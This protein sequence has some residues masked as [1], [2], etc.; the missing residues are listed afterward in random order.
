MD[1]DDVRG[2]SIL[3]DLAGQAIEQGAD[4][5]C[6]WA[7]VPAPPG[8][9]LRAI[10]LEFAERGCRLPDHL[11]LDLVER[12]RQ[13]LPLGRTGDTFIG[14]DGALWLAPTFP[15]SWRATRPSD[16]LSQRARGESCTSARCLSGTRRD[17]RHVPGGAGQG[18]LL[19]PL[20][21][22]RGS[23]GTAGELSA[24]ARQLFPDAC[25]RQDRAIANH[26]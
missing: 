22:G 24:I 2:A 12:T 21:T 23:R 15:G 1:L 10:V 4:Q 16:L 5:R 8:V 18:R 6:G 25:A 17:R 14:W 20:R 3:E 7:A 9:R 19:P 13:A 26:R 11:V